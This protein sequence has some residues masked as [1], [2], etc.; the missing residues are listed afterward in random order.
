MPLSL[1]IA[2]SRLPTGIVTPLT[3]EQRPTT[4]TCQTSSAW[5][6][7][8]N[9]I[10]QQQ[11]WFLETKRKR[12]VRVWHFRLLLLFSQ[13]SHVFGIPSAPLHPKIFGAAMPF[14][15]ELTFGPYPAFVLFARSFGY[16]FF[17]LSSL[18]LETNWSD[19]ACEPVSALRNHGMLARIPSGGSRMLDDCSCMPDTAGLDNFGFSCQYQGSVAWDVLA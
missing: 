8:A 9:K 5:F 19:M 15:R 12:H 4:R 11:L 18:E 3:A 16:F 10:G 1:I 6:G 2:D 13:L 17:S 7:I 14:F